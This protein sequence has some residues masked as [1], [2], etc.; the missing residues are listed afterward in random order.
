LKF[1]TATLTGGTLTIDWSGTGRL[2]QAAT[3]TGHNSDWSD[4]A[5]PP[6]PYTV[7]VGTTGQNF[8]RLISP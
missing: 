4:V 5:N 3:L 6:K 7:Q 1:T 2:Q 8:Y